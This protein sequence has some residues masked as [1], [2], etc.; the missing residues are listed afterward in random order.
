MALI[1]NCNK[2]P[3]KGKASKPGD[4]NPYYAKEKSNDAI[5]VSKDTKHLFKAA[6]VG[7]TPDIR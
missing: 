6:F 7:Q 1:A 4:F 2:D 3:R 5:V